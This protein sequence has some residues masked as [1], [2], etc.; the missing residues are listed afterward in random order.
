LGDRNNS[1]KEET[2]KEFKDKVAVITGTASGIGRALA[3][4]SVREGMKV[5]LAGINE[6]NLI[7]A[8]GELKASGGAVVSVRTDVAKRSDM[9]LLA[10]KTLDT[11][12]AVHLLV[13]NAGV[14]M[15]VSSWEATWNDWEW[16]IGVNLW[17][18]I[19]GIKVFTPLML[20]Q[21]TECYIV[22][23]ASFAGLMAGYPG[24]PYAVTKHAVVALSECLYLELEQRKAAVKV[25]VLCPGN[26]KT[27]IGNAE[28]NR[29]SGLRD[30]PVELSPEAQAFGDFMKAFIE[31]G[32]SPVQVADQVFDA[33]KEERFYILT[34]PEFTPAIKMRMAS[35]LSGENPQN[36]AAAMMKLIK[37][38]R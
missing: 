18:V 5:V 24:A 38:N 30:E 8:E 37:L 28:R 22:N 32:M 1:D 6:A 23:T 29:P 10:R 31:A 34:H 25:S 14:S 21:N 17:G 4:R 3:E 11:F 26:V 2:M 9:E 16:V 15:R 13:N 36:A 35:L 12:G 27:N 19:H 7:K 20:S 33:I